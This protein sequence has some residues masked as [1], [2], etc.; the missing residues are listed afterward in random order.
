MGIFKGVA[1][2]ISGTLADQWKSREMIVGLII[3]ILIFGILL[4]MLG[5]PSLLLY[6]LSNIEKSPKELKIEKLGAKI[7]ALEVI[8]LT[9]KDAAVLI[10][11]IDAGASIEYLVTKEGF[12]DFDEEVPTSN[13]DLK[14]KKM[15][16]NY[17][18]SDEE[19]RGVQQVSLLLE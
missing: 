9:G 19:K 3:V 4:F 16:V 11:E 7:E 18:Y 14:V 8:G 13:L 12:L 6:N 10:K 5:G 17:W 15:D 1:D 2:S